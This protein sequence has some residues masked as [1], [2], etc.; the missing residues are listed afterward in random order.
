MNNMVWLLTFDYHVVCCA[1]WVK[2]QDTYNFLSANLALFTFT[3][4]LSSSCSVSLLSADYS[5]VSSIVE[6]GGTK[7]F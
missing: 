1:E 6:K 3:N 7:L 4:T 2:N 5:R